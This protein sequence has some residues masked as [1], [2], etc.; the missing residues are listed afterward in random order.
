MNEVNNGF[1]RPLQG[2]VYSMYSAFAYVLNLEADMLEIVIS[3]KRRLRAAFLPRISI[4]LY[5]HR[6]TL[7]GRCPLA[8]IRD[9]H[10]RPHAH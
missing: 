2:D 7:V 9:G 10:C 3:E 5:A 6:Q 4:G 8:E 1:R